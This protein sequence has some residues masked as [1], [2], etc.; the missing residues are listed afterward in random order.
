MTNPIFKY[1]LDITATAVENKVVNEPYSVGAIRARIFV[2]SGGPFYGNS[3][4]LYDA[5]TGRKLIPR[6]DY[7]LLHYYEEA[8]D[9]TLKP[10]YAAIQIINSEVSENLLLTTQYV[11]G[12]FSY[13]Y[14]AIVQ[15]LEELQNDNRPIAWGDLIGVPAEFVP[16]NHLHDTRNTYGWRSMVDA[17]T[18]VETA[19]L[20]G[21]QTSM[22][23]IV[24]TMN[25][26][27]AYIDQWRTDLRTEIDDLETGLADWKD[28]VEQGLANDWDNF[29]DDVPKYAKPL[30]GSEAVLNR[31][32]IV[33]RPGDFV[34][35][36]PDNGY[37]S[38][39]LTIP[40]F[41]NLTGDETFEFVLPELP[42]KVRVKSLGHPFRILEHK[43]IG[44]P[45]PDEVDVEVTDYITR[46]RGGRVVGYY[47]AVN[48]AWFLS[49]I[50]SMLDYRHSTLYV[51]QELTQYS[52][53]H[54][55]E[56]F[57]VVPGGYRTIDTTD[58][59][60]YRGKG[61]RKVISIFGDEPVV[62]AS[63]IE[64]SDGTVPSLGSNLTVV[65]VL[66]VGS[67]WVGNVLHKD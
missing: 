1:A 33:P 64:W 30:V 58:M 23:L 59:V 41:D 20:Q 43:T 4:E 13:V 26:K 54:E 39:T 16:T 12:E 37:Y 47:S 53:W 7:R 57:Q 10:V 14:Y 62:W 66:L 49:I 51:E 22:D 60:F 8:S 40:Q 61:V 32:V 65:E 5:A 52:H 21:S 27:I 11:G 56:F 31:Q 3:T 45:V 67:R 35:N 24:Q 46:M 63:R 15:A 34:L 17:L 18:R 48:N 55:A 44:S 29:R 6:V 9:R 2:P 38:Q 25:Q 36:N 19:I 42:M 28:A 50:G